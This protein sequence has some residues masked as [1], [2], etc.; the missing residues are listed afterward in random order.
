MT[1]RLLLVLS[2]LLLVLL[3]AGPAAAHGDGAKIALNSDGL[4]AVWVTIVHTDGHEAELYE[5]TVSARSA[6]GESVAAQDLVKSSAPGTYV[7]MGTLAA[8][9]WDVSTELGAPVFL[10]CTASFTMGNEPKT[11]AVPCGPSAAASD[12]TP[13]EGRDVVGLVALI[14]AV[15]GAVALGVV[16]IVLRR[17]RAAPPPPVKRKRVAARR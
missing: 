12:A 11:T 17:R 15:V 2:G 10:T 16:A 13:S 6:S 3:P 1:R 4:G 14:A 5:G 7:Y 9:T 8:G